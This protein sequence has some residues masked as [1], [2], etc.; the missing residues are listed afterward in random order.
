MKTRSMFALL[1]ASIIG[2][3]A[4]NPYD[5]TLPAEPFRCGS[6]EPR[7]PESYSCKSVGNLEVCQATGAT[8]PDAPPTNDIVCNNDSALEPNDATSNAYAVPARALGTAY[9]LSGIAICPTG[10]DKDYYAI[11]VDANTTNIEVF[12]NYSTGAPLSLSILNGSGV[13]VANG[14]VSANRNRAFLAN[15]ASG[16]YYAFVS[17]AGKNNYDM[18]VT[19]TR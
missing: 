19:Q 16:V 15:A 9:M 3:A 6:V 10:A 13:P 11:T 12:I 7:C 17:G 4:C 1:I 5:P 2:A 8:L 18:S 14:V